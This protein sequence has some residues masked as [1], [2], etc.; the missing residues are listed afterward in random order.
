MKKKI[1]VLSLLLVSMLQLKASD[2]YLTN[3]SLNTYL[4]TNTNYDISV[5]VKNA[6]NTPVTNFTLCWQLD[7][8]TVY[9]KV[10]GV[11]GGGITS[12][13]YLPVIHTNKLTIANSGNYHIKVWICNTMTSDNNQANDTIHKDV[14]VLS[15]YV[16][17]KVLIEEF[18]AT[19]C[20][21]CP[22]GNSVLNTISNNENAVVAA[23]HT[24]GNY[25]TTQTSSYASLTG[26]SATPQAIINR[27]EFGT[28]NITSNHANWS[29]DVTNRIGIS[30]VGI[31]FTQNYNSTNRLLTINTKVNFKEAFSGEYL[32]NIYVLESRIIG[33]QA[34]ASSNYTHNHVVRKLL[35]GTE[36]FSNFIPLQPTANMDYTRQDTITIPTAW[37]AANLEI[38]AYIYQKNQNNLRNVLN[39]SKYCFNTTGLEE[40]E[41]NSLIKHYPNPVSEQL[42]LEFNNFTN[43]KVQVFSLDGKLVIDQE[44]QNVNFC[45]I[46]M[47]NLNSGIYII[48]ITNEESTK[49]FKITKL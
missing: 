40:M 20:Q 44:Y 9:S 37:N 17:K 39:V 12:G 14:M 48:Q 18:T 49:S 19:S 4:K 27:G 16:T 38:V 33:Y 11:G 34:G 31:S 7:N 3:F 43:N 23:M 36:G 30:P 8:G 21:Y 1:L 32:V 28:Y 26:C 2:A 41:N 42:T 29:Q 45:I 25:A 10:F 5:T 46:P 47:S 22:A 6:N 24:T 35:G 15:N 13:N